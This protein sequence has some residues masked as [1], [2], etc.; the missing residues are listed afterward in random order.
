MQSCSTCD[1][2]GRRRIPLVLSARMRIDVCVTRDDRHCFGSGG[3]HFDQLRAHGVGHAHD[4]FRTPRP[5]YDDTNR[6]RG[7]PPGSI[8]T[9]AIGDAEGR[10][11]DRTCC[12]DAVF[13][14]CNMHGPVRSAGLAVLTGAVERVDDPHPTRSQPREV[15]NTFLRQ[16]CIRREASGKFGDD[17]FMTESIGRVLESRG[18]T[19]VFAEGFAVFE[20]KFSSR[21]GDVDRRAFIVSACHRYS[22]TV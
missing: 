18:I 8:I 2:N 1:G 11:C 9:A 10:H 5:R 3:S 13:G 12:E 20:Q 17:E 16:H 6:R 15:V 4:R 14:Q 7:I 21:G 22:T 19:V